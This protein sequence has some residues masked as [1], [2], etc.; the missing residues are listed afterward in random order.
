MKSVYDVSWMPVLSSLLD[1]EEVK[2]LIDFIDRERQQ[3]VVY[4]PDNLIFNAFKLT[5]FTDVKVVILGQDPYHNKG[6]AQGLSFSVPKGVTLP[7]SLRNIYTELENDIRGFI[8]PKHGDL[9]K[10]AQQGVLLLNTVLTVREHQAGSHQNRGWE[11]FTDAVI[12]AVSR[13]LEHVVFVLWGSYAQKKE[14]LIDKTK[15][16]ILKSVHPSPLSAYRGFF[17]CR[18]FSLANNYLE[19]SGKKGV[20]WQL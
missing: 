19:M 8:R 17:G 15:H 10:W 2:N 1:K 18:H 9:T 4:P 7:P 14:K 11:Q 13:D 6:Q 16:L 5:K 20:D 3:V 12:E